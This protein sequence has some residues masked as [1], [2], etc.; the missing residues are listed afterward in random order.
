[1][2]EIIDN[3]ASCET[4]HG[5][6]RDKAREVYSCDRCHKDEDVFTDGERDLCIECLAKRYSDDLIG[7]LIGS[8]AL[9]EWAEENFERRA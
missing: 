8:D 7:W 2:K 9:T 5:C 1:M 3:C 4:C 6:G